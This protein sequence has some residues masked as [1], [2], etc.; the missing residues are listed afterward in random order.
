MFEC[1]VRNTPKQNGKAER[2]FATF[3]G[4]IRAMMIMQELLAP[5]KCC[6]IWTEA[7]AM[8]IKI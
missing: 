4:R 2:A 6:K 7:A 3:S 8:T 1:T 5:E